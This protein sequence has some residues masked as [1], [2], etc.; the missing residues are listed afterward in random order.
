MTTDVEDPTMPAEEKKCQ[1]D[2]CGSNNHSYLSIGGWYSSWSLYATGSSWSAAAFLC[3]FCVLS[4]CSFMSV[5]SFGSSFSVLSTF[6]F[7]SVGCY[8]ESFKIC[9]GS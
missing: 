6:S 1:K 3:A 9:W 8:K 2:E 7:M 4:S 5:L